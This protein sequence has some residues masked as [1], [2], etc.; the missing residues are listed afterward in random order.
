MEMSIGSIMNIKY[1]GANTYGEYL[2]LIL[3]WANLMVLCTMPLTLGYY[4]YKHFEHL[5]DEK[6]K[7]KLGE[8]VESIN[9]EKLSALFFYPMFMYRRLL[10]ILIAIFLTDYPAM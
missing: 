2:S 3:A 5:E 9:T 8:I 7:E 4:M 1:N 6:Y 10:F